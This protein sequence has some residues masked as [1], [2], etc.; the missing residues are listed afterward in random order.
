VIYAKYFWQALKGKV[1]VN[2]VDLVDCRRT[3][4]EARRFESRAELRAYT[5]R[6]SKMFPKEEA[7]RNGFLAALLITL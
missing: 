4:E 2:I 3:G 6:K 1:W 7:K 5:R